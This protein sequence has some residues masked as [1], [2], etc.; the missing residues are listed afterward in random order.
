[1]AY[2]TTITP[3]LSLATILEYFNLTEADNMR[4]NLID[5]Y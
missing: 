5:I 4:N 1:M 2:Y 3:Y